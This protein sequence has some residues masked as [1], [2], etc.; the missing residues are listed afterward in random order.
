[1]QTSLKIG[2]AQISLAPQKVQVAQILGASSPPFLESLPW[3][4]KR[5]SRLTCPDLIPGVD[6]L[7]S[8]FTTPFFEFFSPV[9][10]LPLGEQFQ[11]RSLLPSTVLHN[12]VRILFYRH[13]DIHNIHIFRHISTP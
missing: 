3:L 8:C 12:S 11:F 7:S 1:M 13:Q 10:F 9:S 4:L 6:I 2:F 5:P